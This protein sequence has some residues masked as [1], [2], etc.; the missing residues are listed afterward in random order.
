MFAVFRSQYMGID[1]VAL[2]EGY[3][4]APKAV[5]EAIDEEVL[6]LAM[7]LA[8]IVEDEIVPPPCDL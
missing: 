6:A 2:S 3:V 8:S 4:D 1:L 5:L 7:T